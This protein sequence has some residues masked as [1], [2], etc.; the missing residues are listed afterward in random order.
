MMLANNRTMTRIPSEGIRAGFELLDREATIVG[1]LLLAGVLVTANR[2]PGPDSDLLQSEYGG[3]MFINQF[4]DATAATC[5][6][7]HR[8][9]GDDNRQPRFFHE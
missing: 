5:N 1:L 9:V 3:P 8:I 7:G 2:Q 4:D 6:A